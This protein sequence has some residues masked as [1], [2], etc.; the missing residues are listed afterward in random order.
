M[1]ESHA[2]S[3][4]GVDKLAGDWSRFL[5]AGSGGGANRQGLKQGGHGQQTR[6]RLGAAHEVPIEAATIKRH[7]T[8]PKGSPIVHALYAPVVNIGESQAGQSTTFRRT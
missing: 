7:R 8:S 5:L 4:C 6:K 1:P 2:E 3:L